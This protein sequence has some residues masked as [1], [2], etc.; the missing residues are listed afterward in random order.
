VKFDLADSAVK[1][2]HI[3]EFSNGKLVINVKIFLPQSKHFIRVF[4]KTEFAA[5]EIGKLKN[6]FHPEIVF[7]SR[8]LTKLKMM[9]K[10]NI[11]A[12]VIKFFLLK[13]VEV[14]HPFQ[15]TAQV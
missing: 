5:G 9:K 7:E 3:P 15:N 6:C 8:Q 13:A 12:H 11:L 1:D 10:W 14:G 2:F 4:T